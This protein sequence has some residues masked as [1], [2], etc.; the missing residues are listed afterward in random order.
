MRASFVLLVRV[1]LIEDTEESSMVSLA[2]V[3]ET[4]E[5]DCLDSD[6][7][8]GGKDR[9]RSKSRGASC[10]ILVSTLTTRTAK[11]AVAS[12]SPASVKLLNE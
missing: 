1:V 9:G 6:W 3:M 2:A 11:V 5:D 7:G 10:M 4:G 12:S 8:V